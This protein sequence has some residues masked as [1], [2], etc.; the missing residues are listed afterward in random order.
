MRIGHR[1]EFLKL[2]FRAL[3]AFHQ[4][5]CMDDRLFGELIN[6]FTD[7]S[8]DRLTEEMIANE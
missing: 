7:W 4:S 8:I 1:R 3:V 5:E 6:W 2:T